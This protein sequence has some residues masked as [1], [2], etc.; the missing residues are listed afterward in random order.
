MKSFEIKESG[1]SDLKVIKK[2]KI[3]DDRGFLSRFFC[4][5]ELEEAGWKK[6]IAQI[7]QTLTI[8]KGTIRGMHFQ[9]NLSKEMKFVSCLNGAVYDVAIDIRRGSKTF[10]KHF[11][12]ELSEENNYSLLIPEGFAHGF[13][14]LTDD[15]ELLYLHSNFYSSED[16]DGLNPLDERLNINWPLE[17]F[18]IS[19]K[20]NNKSLID[21]KY[22]GI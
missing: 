5:N 10:L 8:K 6:P 19:T 18:F 11:A 21:S 13:Q 1:I 7:N 15:V 14:A 16:E 17:N 22:Q 12:T 2:T 3:S 9:K 20:D 4:F